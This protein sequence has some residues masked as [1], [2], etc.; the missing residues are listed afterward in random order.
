LYVGDLDQM[1]T[2]PLLYNIF[3]PFG[4][5]VSLRIINLN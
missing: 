1:I 5:V 4:P 3:Q 2:E